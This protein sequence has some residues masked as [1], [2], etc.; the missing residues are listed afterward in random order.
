[1]FMPGVWFLYSKKNIIIIFQNEKGNTF[2]LLIIFIGKTL[3]KEQN[4]INLLLVRPQSARL[5]VQSPQSESTPGRLALAWNVY[6]SWFDFLFY[7]LAYFSAA[8]ANLIFKLI[9]MGSNLEVILGGNSGSTPKWIF[10]RVSMN[11]LTNFFNLHQFFCFLL[12]IVRVE[13]MI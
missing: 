3:Q 7:L 10:G 6:Q 13:I 1:M 4:S 11:Y 8:K 2:T 9:Q 5:N 12:K